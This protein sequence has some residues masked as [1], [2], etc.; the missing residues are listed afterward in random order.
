M[1]TDTRGGESTGS[2]NPRPPRPFFAVF[3]SIALPMFISLID[4]TIVS[5]AL[6]TIAAALGDVDN[7][8]W[9]MVAYLLA[10]TIAAP[11]YGRLGD[12]FG[13]RRML[14]WALGLMMTA[15]VLCAAAPNMTWLIA[16]R[17]VQ[18]AGSGGLMA[19]AYALLAERVLPRERAYYQG[20][21]SAIGISAASFGPVA[22]GFLAEHLGWQSIF[23]VNLVTGAIAVGLTFR[24]PR[25]SHV[26][27]SGGFDWIGLVLFSG[28]V[29]TLLLALEWLKRPDPG[30]ILAASLLLVAGAV[31]VIL[32]LRQER[33]AKSPLIPLQ[34]FS[35]P[36]VR[37]S[38]TVSFC[39]NVVMLGMLM[40]L[41]LYLAVVR[42]AAPSEIGLLLLPMTATSGMGAYLTGQLIAR[43]GYAPIITT[44][45]LMIVSAILILL[46]FLA[47]SLSLG[48][49]TVLLALYGI[50]MGSVN[51]VMQLL[52]QSDSDRSVM[53]SAM[54]T[55]QIARALGSAVGPALAAVVL[56]GTLITSGSAVYNI[57]LVIMSNSADATANLQPEARG[58]LVDNVAA[59]FELAFVAIAAVAAAGAA[60][61]CFI[62]R[63]R[64]EV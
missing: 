38:M 27:G 11:V 61:S 58:M 60:I 15:S 25:G 36:T 59:A 8:S 9:V 24:L 20:Y 64:L 57:F 56:F 16:A 13:R 17:V 40:L 26:G 34:V 6:P 45:G 62:P 28:A 12:I 14:L 1:P 10:M 50:A 33:R 32:L 42:S 3:P 44:V 37:R 53:G 23:L 30:N 2:A 21:L 29:M 19:T 39:H 47:E 22:G 7:Y 41:P 35:N 46:A 63:R 5:T 31:T 4:Q 55:I 48:A 18:G 43:T 52:V 54:A 49:I 51:P